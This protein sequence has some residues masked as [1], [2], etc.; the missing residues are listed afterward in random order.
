MAVAISVLEG[1]ASNTFSSIIELL[2]EIGA[3]M[4]KWLTNRGFAA[5]S[6]E[7]RCFSKVRDVR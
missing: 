7:I 2:D 1:S 5:D 3:D 4:L 6:F